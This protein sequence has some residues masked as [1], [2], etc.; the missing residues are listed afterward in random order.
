M[1]DDQQP[2]RKQPGTQQLFA[3][4]VRRHAW[5]FGAVTIIGTYVVVAYVLLPLTWMF[6]VHRHPALGETPGTTVTGDDHPAFR[7]SPTFTK[8]EKG[9]TV[10]ETTGKRTVDC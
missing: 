8:F 2:E 6:Y 9:T 1:N 10:V 4:R 5:L 7:S 3:N